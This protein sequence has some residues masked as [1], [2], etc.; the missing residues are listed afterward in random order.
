MNRRTTLILMI[1]TVAVSSIG[2]VGTGA[3]PA[4]PA[5]LS[6]EQLDQVRSLVKRTQSE[7]TRLKSALAE[8]QEKLAECY[9]VF[10]LDEKQVDKLQE[11]IIE[12]QRKLLASHHSMQT[13]LRTIVGPER[14][15]ILSRRI[16]NAMQS[17]TPKSDGKD[18]GQ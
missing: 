15:K 18:K 16:A 1:A 9:T 12:L 6:T 14:F 11:E 13:E 4:S 3:D 2:L 10:E 8:S 5:P 17:P 7:Q